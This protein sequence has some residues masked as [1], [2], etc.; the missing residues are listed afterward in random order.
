MLALYKN[1][2]GHLVKISL[3]I[4]FCEL[5]MVVYYEYYQG[6]KDYVYACIES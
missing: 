4:R 6:E 3:E 5:R 2:K 1:D